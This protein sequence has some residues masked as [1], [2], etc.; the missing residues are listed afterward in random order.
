M[1]GLWRCQLWGGGDKA[2]LKVNGTR[3]TCSRDYYST[4]NS[5]SMAVPLRS[6]Q[7]GREQ[8]IQAHVLSSHPQEGAQSAAAKVMGVL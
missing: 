5:C 8:V 7:R 4:P 2:H 6:W 1:E 3:C